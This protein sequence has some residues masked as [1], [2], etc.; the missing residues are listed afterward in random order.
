ANCDECILKVMNHALHGAYEMRYT[1]FAPSSLSNSEPSCAT[2]MATGRPQAL[3]SSAI[4]PVRKSMYSPVGSPLTIGTC[5]TLWP[6]RCARFQEPFSTAK[7]W[8]A[9]SAG[10]AELPDGCCG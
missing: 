5:T 4:K 3:P 9:Y 10:K 2:L 8:P 7:P 6:V 1:M